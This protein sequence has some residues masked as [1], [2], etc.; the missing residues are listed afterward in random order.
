M[1]AYASPR[2]KSDSDYSYR[3]TTLSAAVETLT[4]HASTLP[5]VPRGAVTSPSRRGMGM[6]ASGMRSGSGGGGGGWT[7]TPRRGS[8]DVNPG[9]GFD[10]RGAQ[11]VAMRSRSTP[12]SPKEGRSASPYSNNPIGVSPARGGGRAG[13]AY[14]SQRPHSG[15]LFLSER[16]P[17]SFESPADRYAP[18]SSS[19]SS[20]S[21]SASASALG[22]KRGSDDDAVGRATSG[23][24]GTPAG[25]IP[26]TI[27]GKD[28]TATQEDMGDFLS[29][30]ALG[31]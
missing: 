12:G 17:V 29:K 31:L 1:E 27:R 28:A 18:A 21:A 11:G 25:P 22:Q 7:G 30:L 23:S 20:A 16:P 6:I 8:G 4:A 10:R 13:D 14:G 24:S 2:M 26:T 15:G 5:D 3:S 9:S 19:T